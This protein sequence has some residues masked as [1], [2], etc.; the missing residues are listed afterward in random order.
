MSRK[1]F[2]STILLLLVLAMTACA[3][4]APDVP[5]P[6]AQTA[7]ET[8]GIVGDEAATASVPF[9]SQGHR[10][11]RGLRPENTL[12]AFETA[13]DLGVT[14]L[15]LDLHFSADDQVVIWHDPVI[16]PAKCRINPAASLPLPDPDDPNTALADLALRSLTAQQLAAYLCDR[17]PDPSRF[18]DQ[19]TQPT[20]LAGQD[21]GI[22]TLARL[23]DFVDAYA[24]DPAKSEAQRTN[25]AQVRFNIE[26]KR[27]FDQPQA[28][29][30]GFDGTTPGP[31]ELAILELVQARGLADRVVVQSFDH[32]SLWA[33]HSVAPEMTLAVLISR[34]ARGNEL[35]EWAQAGASIFSPN[36][37]RL[38]AATVIQ[39]HEAGLTVIPW[40]VNDPADMRRLIDMGVDGLISDRPDLLVDLLV[41]L[42][43]NL[44]GT[45]SRE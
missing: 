26:T 8:P 15:E 22:V 14:T 42:L 13:L 38:T 17:N 43:G 28:I 44:A 41:D 24:G 37:T 29:G 16:D 21:F 18:P 35:A 19:T 11:A 34:A 4:P 31:F 2:R 27:K 33:V 5:A 40:T 23:F 6:E 45:E 25:A 7:L 10:G 3:T 30:D 36:A 20:A 12:P 39:A 9:D 32:R 1:L